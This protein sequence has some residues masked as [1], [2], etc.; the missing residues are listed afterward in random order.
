LLAQRIFA[1]VLKSALFALAF[2]TPAL[3]RQAPLDLAC[4]GTVWRVETPP[5]TLQGGQTDFEGASELPTRTRTESPTELL[6]IWID[7]N[8]AGKVR[9]PA[10]LEPPPR[11]NRPEWW[12]FVELKLAKDTISGRISLDPLNKPRIRFDRRT[13]QVDLK[14]HGMRFRGA[15]ERV[16]QTALQR[17]F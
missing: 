10:S 2:A 11:F 13:G 8:G 16:S 7:G 1:G 9:L 14:G 12:D 15:C 6:R 5:P 4:Q 3:A 17:P